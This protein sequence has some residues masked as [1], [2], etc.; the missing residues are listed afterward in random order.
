MV[1]KAVRHFCAH[2]LNSIFLEFQPLAFCLDN[3][4]K[5]CIQNLAFT[6]NEE[7]D[8]QNS[9]FIYVVAQCSENI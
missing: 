7:Y 2:I 5:E 3:V 6:S 4:R 8:A 1:K 9:E